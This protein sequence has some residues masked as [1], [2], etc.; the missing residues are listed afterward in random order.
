MVLLKFETEKYLE[1]E[2]LKT[3]TQI[4]ADIYP[5]KY[6]EVSWLWLKDCGRRYISS[7]YCSYLILGDCGYTWRDRTCGESLLLHPKQSCKL[8]KIREKIVEKVPMGVCRLNTGY[9]WPC[10][11]YNRET[12]LNFQD[13]ERLAI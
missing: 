12:N 13:I 4:C 11:I 3:H 1:K 9:L 7:F 6:C 2:Y 10:S 5:K 8:F